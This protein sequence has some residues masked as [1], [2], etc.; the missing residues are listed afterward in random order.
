MS[1]ENEGIFRKNCLERVSSPEKLNEYIRIASPSLIIILAAVFTILI[2]GC[3]W[4]FSNSIP[5]YMNINGVAVISR[6]DDQTKITKV[7]SYISLSEAQKLSIDM[8]VCVS[9]EHLP[10]EENGYINGKV[11]KIGEDV[12]TSEYLY[13]KFDYPAILSS[14][15]PEGSVLEIEIILGEWSNSQ[16]K[17]IKLINGTVCNLSVVVAKQRAYELIFNT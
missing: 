2:A 4:I 15:I 1:D 10:K 8:D 7:Y 11:S 14:V 5:K 13:E 9:P 3:I 17:D 6:L 12:V 16:N